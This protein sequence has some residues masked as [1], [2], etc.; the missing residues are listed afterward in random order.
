[1]NRVDEERRFVARLKTNQ[2]SRD[3][4]R[5][6]FTLAEVMVS[7]GV[8]AIVAA[9]IYGSC[10]MALKMMAA[11]RFRLEA[12]AAAVDYAMILSRNAYNNSSTSSL[13][14]RYWSTSNTRVEHI[15]DLSGYRDI[16]TAKRNAF[17]NTGEI[18]SSLTYSVT[19][20]AD[21]EHID[22]NVAVFASVPGVTN[23]N[24]SLER[25]ATATATR[26]NTETTDQ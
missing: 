21:Q 14:Q 25:L 19:T 4:R 10:I 16:P 6:Q 22:V 12:Q 17:I 7:F 20:T 9:G 26:Y 1:M 8:M 11:S 5:R 3:W 2:T 24:G 23:K 13:V 15:A 18:R